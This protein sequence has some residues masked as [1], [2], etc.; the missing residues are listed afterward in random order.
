M[1]LNDLINNL[2]NFKIQFSNDMDAKIREIQVSNMPLK[3]MV[4]ND[5]YKYDSIK[6]ENNK[7]IIRL[8]II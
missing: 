7:V 6:L 4:F 1:N 2:T 8:M 5:E 3:F